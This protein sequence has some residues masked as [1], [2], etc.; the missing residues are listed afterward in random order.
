M[1]VIA[2]E[3]TNLNE[4]LQKQCSAIFDR[5]NVLVGERVKEQQI[6]KSRDGSSSLQ[7]LVKLNLNGNEER[8]LSTLSGYG[9]L[10]DVMTA[11]QNKNDDRNLFALILAG[12]V[13]A[14]EK[15]SWHVEQNPE[16]LWKMQNWTSWKT[17]VFSLSR[18]YYS[19]PLGTD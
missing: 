19:W 6:R 1:S 16:H 13:V 3:L 4:L 5:C 18:K 7:S 15:R 12:Q 17:Y 2:A 9:E 8:L 11:Y 14:R 10:Y